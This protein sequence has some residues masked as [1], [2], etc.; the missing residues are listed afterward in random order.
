MNR[1]KRLWPFAAIFGVLVGGVA[2]AK[3][4]T[5]PSCELADV[6]TAVN[7]ASAGDTVVIPAGACT[8]TGTLSITK[9]LTLTGS[10]TANNGSS[11]FGAGTV[12]TVITDNSGTNNP[13]ISV[14]GLLPGQFARVSL[15]DIEPT[16][17]TEVG[18]PIIITGKCSSSGCANFRLDNIVWGK[19][20]Y[21]TY[22]PTLL[23]ETLVSTDNIFGVVDHNTVAPGSTDDR[24]PEF[25]NIN[26]TSWQGVGVYGD[27]S[28]ASPDTFGSGQAVYVENND[29]WLSENPV[30]ENEFPAQGGT[31]GAGGG[32][33]VGRFNQ[34]TLSNAGPFA[35]HGTETSGRSRSGRA[36]EIYG[37]DFD[38]LGN[39]NVYAGFRGGTGFVFGN[40][41]TYS[42][43]E[44]SWINTM[45]DIETQRTWRAT[46]WAECN[47]LT[48]FDV[49]DG[50][51]QVW[52][53]TM[54]SV[55]GTGPYTINVSGTPWTADAYDFSSSTPGKNF[56][57]VWDFTA[58]WLAGIASNTAS[59]LT[60]NFA[61]PGV[62]AYP[63]TNLAAGDDIA[64]YSS[65]LYA[66]GTHTGTSGTSTLTDSTK[67]WTAN[68]WVG[69]NHGYALI[70]LTQSGLSNQIGANATNTITAA[71][72]ACC[73]AWNWNTGDE[74]IIT[75]YTKCLDQGGA[76]AGQLFANFFI[77]PV[78]TTTEVV[79]PAYEWD[80][81]GPPPDHGNIGTDSPSTFTANVQ[82]YTD[83]S[84]GKPVECS[85]TH[86]CASLTEGVAWGKLAYRPTTCTA[87]VGYY[88]TDQG[89]WNQSGNAF[90]QGQFFV[91]GAGNTWQARYAPYCY[92]HPLVSGVS[93]SSEAPDGGRP[94][95]GGQSGDGGSRVD[96]GVRGEGGVA[97]GGGA[98]HESGG[99]SSSGCGCRLTSRSTRGPAVALVVVGGLALARR[100]RARQA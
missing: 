18:W 11:E 78:E 41:W 68:Q 95:D 33:F 37:N 17:N 40:T 59:S 61:I 46:N 82:Y 75:G 30:T 74:F 39:C 86:A 93:C 48:P 29:I 71:T 90:G 13:L 45:L 22:Q 85:A 57:V 44:D 12:T 56:Y 98:T 66:A 79:D 38:C 67:T 80:N 8:W 53:G 72:P 28:W 63:A 25:I 36:F 60:T 65:T 84:N 49:N 2:S 35:Y 83:N 1:T 6:Q 23:T 7:S 10:G 91:C 88:A 47:G 96:S 62:A 64:I 15:L 4:V 97:D 9:S 50:Y 54:S 5:T 81:A 42:S 43:S 92:P 69:T 77:T 52:K 99:A 89:S 70:D 51:T 87:G 31:N 3:T 55:S 94:T 19:T 24:S 34:L 58:G 14:S 32:R 73:P 16:A 100:R 21:W 27:N 26:L 76:G 20:N